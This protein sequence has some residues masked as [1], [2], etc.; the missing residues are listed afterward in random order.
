MRQLIKK[1]LTQGNQ[2]A[3]QQ[4]LAL[5]ECLDDSQY[6]AA[7]HPVEFG[8]GRHLRHVLDMYR[9]LRNGMAVG[10]V[11]YELRD[12]DSTI[13]RNRSEAVKGLHDVGAWMPG[14][15]EDRALRVHTRVSAA[16]GDIEILESS[17]SRELAFVASH[18]V[19]HLA[20]AVVLAKLQ[21]CVVDESLGLA[22]ATVHAEAVSR[23][24]GQ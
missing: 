20:Y 9:A 3:L 21:G 1:T 12:R 4:W 15:G 13:E 7:P 14:I 18:S 5:L 11:N 6:C 17:L 2:E 10:E 16:V 22:P 19:H 24:G 8:I 23:E